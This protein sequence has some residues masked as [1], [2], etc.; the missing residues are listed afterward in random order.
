MLVNL[1]MNFQKNFDANKRVE[2][3]QP[4]Y[5][6]VLLLEDYNESLQMFKVNL[7]LL[8]PLCGGTIISDGIKNNCDP[9]G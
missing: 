6:N 2:S 8:L 4:N 7:S 9:F 1:C 5:I 3:L